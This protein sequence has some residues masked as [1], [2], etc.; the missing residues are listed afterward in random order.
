MVEKV[1]RNVERM[2]A[3]VIH[4]HTVS[5]YFHAT[6]AEL[7]SCDRGPMTCNTYNIYYPALYRNKKYQPWLNLLISKINLN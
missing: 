7:S 2:T 5:G 3:T 6:V 4:L 1:K